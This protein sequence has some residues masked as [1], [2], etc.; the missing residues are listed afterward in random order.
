MSSVI[1]LNLKQGPVSFDISKTYNEEIDSI[2]NPFLCG[3]W[4]KKNQIH[5][6]LSNESVIKLHDNGVYFIADNENKALHFVSNKIDIISML[7][8]DNGQNTS[9]NNRI[10]KARMLNYS[11]NMIKILSEKEFSVFH[12]INNFNIGDECIDIVKTRDRTDDID[13][14]TADDIGVDLLKTLYQICIYF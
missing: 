4:H 11:D 2:I 10:T 3:H 5:E 6:Q 7:E 12:S 8:I 9:Y 1:K 14:N 13:I